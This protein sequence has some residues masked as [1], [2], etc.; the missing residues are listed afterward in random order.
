MRNGDASQ[1]MYHIIET[2][3]LQGINIYNTFLHYNNQCFILIITAKDI[4]NYSILVQIEYET[5]RRRSK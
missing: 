4:K 2:V 5:L 3:L 1:T